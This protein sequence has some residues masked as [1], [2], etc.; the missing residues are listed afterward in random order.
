MIC[1]YSKSDIMEDRPLRIKRLGEGGFTLVEL[2]VVMALG[3]I[4]MTG[5]MTT[6]TTQHKSYLV[7]D[8]V[9]EIQQNLRVAIDLI[10]G[11]L[12]SAGYNPSGAATNAGIATATAGRLGFTQDLNGNGVTTDANEAITYGFPTADDAT[13]DGIAD[14]GLAN[15]GRNTGTSDGTGGSGFQLLAENIYG[16]EFLYILEDGT[17]TLNPATSQLGLIRSVVVSML[18]VSNTPDNKFTN[19]M[20]YTTGSGQTWGPFNDNLRRRM[21]VTTVLCRNLGL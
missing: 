4:V 11:D 18:A 20:T 3:A 12:R 16:I 10:S 21:F 9:V 17:Q 15:L 2:L 19:S 8:D 14:A 13:F 1:I 5:V 6:F 7:Q